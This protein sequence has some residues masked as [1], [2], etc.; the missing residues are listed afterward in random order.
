MSRLTL[1][2]A[3]LLAVQFSCSLPQVGGIGNKSTTPAQLFSRHSP[4]YWPTTEW[5]YS[6]PEQQGVS[7]TALA[8]ALAHAIENNLAIHSLFVVRHGYVVLDAT[9][10]PFVTGSRHDVASVTKSMTSLA[11]GAAVQHQIIASTTSPVLG[12]LHTQPSRPDERKQRITVANLLGMQSGLDCGFRSGEIELHAML[13]QRDWIHAVLDLPMR[14]APGTDFGYCSGNYHLLSAA[15][16]SIT[17]ESE[18]AF[19][20]KRVFE[21]LGIA[22]V[23][24]PVD[25]V[26]NSHGWGD[27]QLLPSDLAKLGFLMLHGGSWN[28][29]QLV[30]RDWIIWST[31]PRIK[32][33]DD[34][35]YGYGW[36][37]HPDS[38]PG[39]YEA[40]G[41]GGQRLSVWPEKDLVIV[42]LGGGYAPGELSPFLLRSLVSDTALP[43]NPDGNK[44]LRTLV[45]RATQPP[46]AKQFSASTCAN[47]AM[48][49]RFTVAQNPMDL[50]SFKLS[51]P[52][53]DSAHL[54]MRVGSL[55]LSLPVGLD[56]AYRYSQTTIEGLP[57]AAKGEWRNDCTF[58]LE[59]NLVGK[60]D[61][62]QMDMTFVGTSAKVRISERTGLL[63][64]ETTAT[65]QPQ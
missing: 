17:G 39:F 59:L 31:K 55:A 62:Y 52:S 11:I 19:A 41:R 47:A 54:D 15:I 57:P 23:R 43:P 14:S 48:T 56:G 51:F 13:N 24:W 30:G 58:S 44:R 22:D 49:R 9:F 38:P 63:K 7:S 20:R 35:F 53:P 29:E 3:G 45:E 60:I 1:V 46:L 26:G 64:Y 42:M 65:A 21:P 36:W 18:E 27:L 6:T 40:M 50:R 12:L 28:G 4:E 34:N 61:T 16:R 32:Y 37:T 5:R 8:D 25:S 2:V 33:G 10:Y